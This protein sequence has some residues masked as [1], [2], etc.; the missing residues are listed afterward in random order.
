MR[1]HRK[2]FSSLLV[3]LRQVNVIIRALSS[4]FQPNLKCIH[5]AFI[6][7]LVPTS[8]L[9]YQCELTMGYRTSERK[10]FIHQAPDNSGFY[11]DLYQRAAKRIG[12]K[13][14][15]LRAPKKR[16][17][18]ELAFGRVDFY[19]GLSFSVPRSEFTYF[20]P[21][22][23]STRFIGLSRP[24]LNEITDMNQIAK[25]GLIMLVAPG[26]D[27]LDGLP[28]NLNTRQPPELDVKDAISLLE[29]KKGDFYAYEESTLNYYLTRMPAKKLKLHINCCEEIQPMLLGFSKKSPHIS[30]SPNPEFD[31]T[32]PESL[33]NRRLVLKPHSKAAQFATALK[34][35]KKA[36]ITQRLHQLYFDFPKIEGE[37]KP[38]LASY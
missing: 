24:E 20:I 23:L 8:T 4:G 16:I 7:L 18:R 14:N 6:L 3:L 29:E 33:S 5:L 17:L 38:E 9:A 37:P 36:G 10:P 2:V 22:G 26:S 31:P 25:L 11:F 15:V 19:P 1:H 34:Q 30:F 35:M 28:K 13:L 12:C 27:T 21:N 32:K